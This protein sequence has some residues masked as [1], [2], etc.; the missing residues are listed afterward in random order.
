M[1]NAINKFKKDTFNIFGEL[2]I[3]NPVT[4]LLFFHILVN[5]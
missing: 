2:G 3:F 5:F 1:L 4:L